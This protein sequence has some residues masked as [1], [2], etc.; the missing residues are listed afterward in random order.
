MMNT[1]AKPLI[2]TIVFNANKITNEC[3]L[4]SLYK[5]VDENKFDLLIV[6]TSDIEFVL[7]KKY[8]SHININQLNFK[9]LYGISTHGAAI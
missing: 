7:D 1:S 4:E 8:A 6:T 3:F 9:K 5:T 2:A